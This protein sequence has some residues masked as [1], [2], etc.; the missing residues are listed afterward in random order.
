MSRFAKLTGLGAALLIAAAP[1]P[2]AAQDHGAPAPTAAPQTQITPE[3]ARAVAQ[4]HGASNEIDI[5][6][7]IGN[8]NYIELPYWKAPYAYQLE[9]PHVAIPPV[10]LGPI[11][12]DLSPTKHTFFMVLAAVL[13][14]W[15]IS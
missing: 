13:V 15:V 8:A 2:A 12:V 5:M 6:H 7:H 3:T 10:H 1:A 4:G 14:K 11:T 9:L